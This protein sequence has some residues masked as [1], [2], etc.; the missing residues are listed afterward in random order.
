[1][2]PSKDYKIIQRPF[3]ITVDGFP[4][5]TFVF[6]ETD[7]SHERSAIFESQLWNVDMGNRNY[8][9]TFESPASSFNSSENRQIR[10]NMIGSIKFL[11]LNEVLEKGL[12]N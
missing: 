3:Y 5:G 12:I 8:L 1:M 2:D 9:F 6:A 11:E 4:A 7:K 10:E